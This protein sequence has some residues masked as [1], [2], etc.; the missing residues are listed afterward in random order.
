MNGDAGSAIITRYLWHRAHFY[1]NEPCFVHNTGSSSLSLS[2]GVPPATPPSASETHPGP[3]ELFVLRA[4]RI[5]AEEAALEVSGISQLLCLLPA[6]LGMP[7]VCN[8]H[9][10]PLKSADASCL[11]VKPQLLN[12][13][14]FLRISKV[15]F[16][17]FLA[18]KKTWNIA[19]TL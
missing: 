19:E 12:L 14:C 15:D 18:L 9:N 3:G 1:P 10:F 7:A 13:C 16:Q 8:S 17:P 11:L 4:I 5:C 6:C 2:A